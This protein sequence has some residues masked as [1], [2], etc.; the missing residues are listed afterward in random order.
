MCFFLD[1]P[2][3]RTFGDRDA[4]ARCVA[5]LYLVQLDDQYEKL[6]DGD[7]KDAREL[8]AQVYVP[9]NTTALHDAMRKTITKLARG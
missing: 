7:L 8:T 3:Y 5:H 9:R 1:S 2:L 4:E 6:Y